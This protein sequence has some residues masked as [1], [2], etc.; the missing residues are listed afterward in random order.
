LS[1]NRTF[2]SSIENGTLPLLS[3]LAVDGQQEITRHQLHV[4]FAE[5]DDESLEVG[6]GDEQRVRR[7]RCFSYLKRV[8]AFHAVSYPCCVF[9]VTLF[10]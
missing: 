8:N 1:R 7:A 4:T 3:A 10:R 5:M 2:R 9:G 6:S